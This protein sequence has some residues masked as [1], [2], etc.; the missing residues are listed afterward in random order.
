MPIIDLT[1]PTTQIKPATQEH[2]GL[3]SSN[4]KTKLDGIGVATSESAGLVK[5]DGETITI[6]DGVITAVPQSA[7]LKWIELE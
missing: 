5:P 7:S 1:T 3:M 2:N 6:E 4:D